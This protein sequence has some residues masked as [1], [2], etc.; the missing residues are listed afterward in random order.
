LFFA[1]SFKLYAFKLC[2]SMNFTIPQF[3]EMESK[4]VGPLTFKQFAFVAAGGTLSFV[5][6]FSLGK[7]SMPLALA[8]IAVV[9]GVACALAFVKVDGIGLITVLQHYALFLMS[10]QA[11][12]WQSFEAPNQ[13]VISQ[14]KIVLRK[15]PAA[16]EIKTTTQKSNLQKIIDYLETK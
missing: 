6:Y 8:L 1:F 10:P 11:F 7:A 13:L 12:L 3:I 14:E 2:A 16:I 5:L 4:V 15:A 9:M